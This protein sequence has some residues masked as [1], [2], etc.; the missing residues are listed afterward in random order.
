MV[1][2]SGG[3]PRVPVPGSAC[4][5]SGNAAAL[6][7][8]LSSELHPVAKNATATSKGNEE[9]WRFIHPF[10]RFPAR[11][12]SGLRIDSDRC[13]LY[14]G[15]TNPAS[16]QNRRLAQ[17]PGQLVV[18]LTATTRER[19]ARSFCRRRPSRKRPPARRQ[20]RAA[21]GR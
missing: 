7:A 19:P 4:A 11:G 15:E 21:R 6:A 1:T 12:A 5:V 2:G 9:A 8:G 18:L 10:S 20:T 16:G 14:R 3:G 13:F 17:H